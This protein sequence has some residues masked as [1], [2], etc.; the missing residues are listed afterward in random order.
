MRKDSKWGYQRYD[1]KYDPTIPVKVFLTNL[2]SPAWPLGYLHWEG[3]EKVTLC[4]VVRGSSR[5]LR[6]GYDE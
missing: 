5:P 1:M 6:Y 3:L 2:I 4:C